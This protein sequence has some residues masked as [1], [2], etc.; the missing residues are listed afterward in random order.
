MRR[1]ASLR[2]R[3]SRG[4]HEPAAAAGV[5]WHKYLI[6][7]HAPGMVADPISGRDGPL[8]QI[9]SGQKV[10][11]IACRPTARSRSKPT[12]CELWRGESCSLVPIHPQSS[13]EP[14]KKLSLLAQFC[15][16][17]AVGPLLNAPAPHA[18]P[19]VEASIIF[20]DLPHVATPM[21]E[22]DGTSHRPSGTKGRLPRGDSAIFLVQ[23]TV[24]V[25]RLGRTAIGDLHMNSDPRGGAVSHCQRGGFRC[26]RRRPSTRATLDCEPRS[27]ICGNTAHYSHVDLPQTSMARRTNYGR[28]PSTL[29]DFKIDPPSFLTIPIQERDTCPRGYGVARNVVTRLLQQQLADWRAVREGAVCGGAGIG[30][31]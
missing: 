8:N 19:D 3:A 23:A 2:I 25:L 15:R 18:R 12:G 9:N 5:K 6:Y 22:V 13:R 10:P 1:P 16:H 29:S 21:H 20:P 11:R 31:S 24:K 28:R 26:W 27:S 30:T 4:S 17:A 7:I 14:M